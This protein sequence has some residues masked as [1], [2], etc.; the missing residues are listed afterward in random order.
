MGWDSRATGYMVSVQLPFSERLAEG[1]LS[2]FS[3]GKEQSGSIFF[4][5]AEIAVLL[6][7][8]L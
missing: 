1:S 6:Q 8:F 2:I 4:L 5:S 7:K 3:D